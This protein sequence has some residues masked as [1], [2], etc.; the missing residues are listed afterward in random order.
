[1]VQTTKI[2]VANIVAKAAMMMRVKLDKPTVTKYAKAMEDGAQF[3]PILV[4]EIDEQLILADGFHRYS[5]YQKLGTTE[6][7]AE[8]RFGTWDD[9]LLAAAKADAHE[10]LARSPADKEKAV[11][12]LLACECWRALSDRE[13]AREAGVGYSLVAKLRKVVIQV[14]AAGT[15]IATN[16]ATRLG[17]DGKRYPATRSKPVAAPA[18]KPPP[19]MPKFTRE[20]IG[21]PAEGT[22]KEQDPDSPPGVTRAMAFTAKHGHVHIRPLADKERAER[23]KKA[24]SFVAGLRDLNML[25]DELLNHS[26]GPDDLLATL[27]EMNGKSMLNKFDARMSA[28]KPLLTYLNALLVLRP[29]ASLM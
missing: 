8:V 9:A 20:Q 26:M 18:Y 23:E 10:G 1:M 21:A 28:I 7:Q 6:I 13:I 11:K 15:S 5:A 17:K 27:R 14:P 2:S 4:F 24:T 29:L 25:S 22:E 12:A 16:R 3:P 19:P